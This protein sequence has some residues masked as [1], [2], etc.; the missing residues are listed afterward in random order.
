MVY[1][2][3]KKIRKIGWGRE[4]MTNEGRVKSSNLRYY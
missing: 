4:G 2:T 1:R 3:V